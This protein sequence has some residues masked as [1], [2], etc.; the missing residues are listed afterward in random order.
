MSISRVHIMESNLRL[1]NQIQRELFDEADKAWI[2]VYSSFCKKHG[3][4]DPSKIMQFKYKGEH[5]MLSEDVMLRAGVR[6]LHDS[7]V[8]EFQAVYSM[9]VEETR[10]EKSILKNMLAHA[11]MISKYAEDLIDIL[12]EVMHGAINE[13]GFF[14]MD[15]KPLM[16]QSQ[17]DAFKERYAQYTDMFEARKTVG[18]LMQ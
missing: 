15:D 2:K 3:Q 5:F 1:I 12:P 13:S 9:F 18:A 4:L 11:I 17:A 14:Q 16:Q 7:L 10:R 8:D 6:P